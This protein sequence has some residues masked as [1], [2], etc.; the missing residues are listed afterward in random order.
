[1]CGAELLR[2]RIELGRSNLFLDLD[3]PILDVSER[4]FRVHKDVL[5]SLGSSCLARGKMQY[6]TMKRSRQP[7]S[8]I[9]DKLSEK[10]IDT[11]AFLVE[12]LKRIELPGYLRLDTVIPGTRDKLGSLQ[13]RFNLILVTLRRDENA[14]RP[15]LERLGLGPCF[16]AVLSHRPSQSDSWEVKRDLIASSG[17]LSTPTWMIGDSEVDILAGKA[18]G[19][20]TVGVLSGIRNLAALKEAAP[21]FIV[22]D[23]NHLPSLD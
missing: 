22:K 12:W 13:E 19:M 1:M 6:W 14:I 15:Q 4:Y 16:T 3:G 7:L 23:L 20:K 8:S 10:Q 9:L 5:G 2:T 18:L 17:L 21:D 11:T